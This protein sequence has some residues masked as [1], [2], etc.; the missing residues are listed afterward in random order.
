MSLLISILI[1]DINASKSNWLMVV[2]IIYDSWCF[3]MHI[4]MCMYVISSLYWI[5]LFLKFG[6]GS[7]EEVQMALEPYLGNP[8][9]FENMSTKVTNNMSIKIPLGWVSPSSQP[10]KR[11]FQPYI[12]IRLVRFILEPIM[13]E[14]CNIC[15]YK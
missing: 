1:N 5:Q 11:G 13:D 14:M 8:H 15:A 12:N 7:H 10:C 3:W 2:W 4:C 9:I 6:T